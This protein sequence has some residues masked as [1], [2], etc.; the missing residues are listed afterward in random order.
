ML[1]TGLKNENVT[2]AL[3]PAPMCIG[4]L[5]CRISHGQGRILVGIR[6]LE[7]KIAHLNEVQAWP[8]NLAAFYALWPAH[9][10]QNWQTHIRPA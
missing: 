5:T 7:G 3:C 10:V 8:S 6:L 1:V 9:G 4:M 2:I